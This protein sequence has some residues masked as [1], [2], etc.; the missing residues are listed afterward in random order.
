MPW[1][2]APDPEVAKRLADFKARLKAVKTALVKVVSSDMSDA[3][4]SRAMSKILLE[5]QLNSLERINA[6][7]QSMGDVNDPEADKKIPELKA[8]L[9]A[10]E[11]EA[12]EAQS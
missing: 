2:Y 3:A 7:R 5:G 4:K 1:K 8:R 6:I 12:E 11:A 9:R 10:L